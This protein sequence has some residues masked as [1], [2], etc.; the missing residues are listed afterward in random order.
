MVID[1]TY[2]YEY[3]ND[4]LRKHRNG[5]LDPETFNRLLKAA[6]LILLDYFFKNLPN[7]HI[8]PFV[9]H[10]PYL[11][12]DGDGTVAFPDDCAF[13][14]SVGGVMLE[15]GS[16]KVYPSTKIQP[17]QVNTIK[18]SR[19]RPPDYEKRRF[20]HAFMNNKVY[21]YPEEYSYWIQFTYYRYPK[22]GVL[23]YS[24]E[25]VDGEDV[26]TLTVA[27][28]MEWNMITLEYFK[29]VLCRAVGINLKDQFAIQATALPN[30]QDVVKP[31]EQ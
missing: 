31:I 16:L 5:Y 12:G 13:H 19:I 10:V 17:N 11:A 26:Q 2:L 24:A 29:S 28:P 23:G 4:L 3:I 18:V 14:D 27:T 20:Y 1:V 15:E 21:V 6:E 7:D 30:F 8:R 25:V 9:K 22:F